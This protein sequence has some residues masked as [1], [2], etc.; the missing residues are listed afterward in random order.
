MA[1]NSIGTLF[2][3]TTFGESHGPGIGSIIDG[4]PPGIALPIPI[5]QAALDRRRPGQS[6]L[7]TSRD[8]PDQIEVLSGLDDDG[9]TLGTP[10]ALI[11]RNRDQQSSAYAELRHQFRPGH[12]DFTWQ[13]KFGRRAW[14]GGGRSSARETAARVAAGAVA[15]L[16][17]ESLQPGLR[18]VAWV[19]R[20]AG[21]DA[22]ASIDAA[23][24]TRALVDAQAVRCPD[25]ATATA[26]AQAIRQARAAGDSVGGCIRLRVT[27]LPA[28]LG[29][30]VFDKLN[31]CLAQALISIPACIGIEF[32]DGFAAVDRR[33]SEH[34]D[35]FTYAAG[36][37]T[38]TN[39]AGGIQGG[40]SN[41][42]P[43]DL[44]LAFRPTATIAR[45][46]TSVD[47][48]GQPCTVSGKGRHDPCVLSRAVPVV[49]AMAAL[50]LCDRLLMQR[51]QCGR[52]Q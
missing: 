22:R 27:G 44:R 24:V 47:Q 14:Q 4:C 25:P 9:R 1:S 45:P 16:V 8:E 43:L 18:L 12:A 37:R 30:P 49:E 23:A 51:G 33:G 40:I 11:I 2:R 52:G 31:A 39:H 13:T 28:G 17:L 50:V 7:T 35:L 3:V 10:L 20:A 15:E 41:G 26:M 32:G 21:L 6:D 19:E 42:M 38:L 48:Q 5:L 29:D 36:V 46:Q 34:N